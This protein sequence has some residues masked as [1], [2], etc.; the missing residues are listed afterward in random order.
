M[1][2]QEFSNQRQIKIK[3]SQK[4]NS[5][6]RPPLHVKN[7]RKIK[8]DIQLFKDEMIV[9]SSSGQSSQATVFFGRDQNLKIRIVVK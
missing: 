6:E 2:P 8:H 5:E 3:V 7:K 4:K 1:K 9:E